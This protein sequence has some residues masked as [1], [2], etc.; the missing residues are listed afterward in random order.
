MVI[1]VEEVAVARVEVKGPCRQKEVDHRAFAVVTGEDHK[2]FVV[3][4][5]VGFAEIEVV[6]FLEVETEVVAVVGPL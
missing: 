4:I 3:A 2:V 5:E 1:L 6:D